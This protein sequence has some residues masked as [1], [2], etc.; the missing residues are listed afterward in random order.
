MLEWFQNISPELATFLLSMVPIVELRGSIPLGIG[1]F[2][3]DPWLTYVLSVVGDIVPAVALAYAL[4]P[5]ER[6]LRM[7]IRAVDRGL[8]WWYS[9]VVRKFAREYERWGALGLVIFVAIPLPMTGS[10][11][12][13]VA[14]HLFNIR[15]WRGIGLVSLGVV[16]AGL[17]VLGLTVGVKGLV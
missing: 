4:P 12:G 1:A 5:I 15:R 11:S 3:L 6:V 10:W 8:T 2:G 17:I 9:R 14:A 13:I 7:R 16:I